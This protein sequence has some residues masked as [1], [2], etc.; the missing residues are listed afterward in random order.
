MRIRKTTE[1]DIERVMKIY[2]YARK[3][4]AEHGNPKQWGATNCPPEQVIRNDIKEG[5]SFVCVN[6][7]GKVI[8]TFY[9]IV[10]KDIEPCYREIYDG[11]WL[12]ASPY[13]VVHRIAADGSEKGIGSFCINWAFD[14]CGH[15]RID[16][17]GDNKVMQ[18][19]LKKL[20]F[21]HCGT[22]YVEEDDDPRL[23]FE[24]S[25]K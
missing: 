7:H 5:N 1:Q 24:K 4:M 12:D 3:F 20:G 13:G 6:D 9:Y 8:G 18:G 23:A 10:G 17:H 11:K 21:T 16:T 2:A 22:V 25:G 14:Q 19:M 15:I